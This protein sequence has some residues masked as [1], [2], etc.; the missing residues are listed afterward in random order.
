M[1][2]LRRGTPNTPEPARNAELGPTTALLITNGAMLCRVA[3]W[4]EAE[5][6]EL[7]ERSRPRGAAH[8]PGRGW[9]APVPVD[10][11]N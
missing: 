6:L 9:F 2:D 7:P 4:T 8:A 3:F 10:G 5:W 1:I 11:L